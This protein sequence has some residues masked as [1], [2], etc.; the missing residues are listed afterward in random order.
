MGEQLV[1]RSSLLRPE[2][3]R[4]STEFFG[5]L[6]SRFLAPTLWCSRPRGRQLSEEVSELHSRDVAL[7][8]ESYRQL[9]L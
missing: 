7:A 5:R 9:R 2:A 4:L 8:H 3:L 6:W 1:R